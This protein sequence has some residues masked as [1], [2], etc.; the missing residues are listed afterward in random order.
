MKHPAEI[1]A[2]QIARMV[3]KGI[4]KSRIAT[5]MGMTYMGV[6]QL[7]QSPEYLQIEDQVRKGVIDKMDERLA[8]RA[9][10]ED[11]LEDA[12]PEAMQVLVEHV[13]EKRDLRA[14]LEVLDRDPEH[15]FTKAS[16]Q[17]QD[18]KRAPGISSEALAKAIAEADL[19]HKIMQESSALV[20]SKPAEA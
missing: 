10:M 16:R 20:D 17:P 6:Y 12:L 11:D 3:V 1:K 9:K 8:K 13:R 4:P 2:E 7:C 14:A 5:E 18:E 19:T 15:L